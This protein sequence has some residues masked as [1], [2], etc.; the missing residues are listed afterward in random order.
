MKTIKQKIAE[1]ISIVGRG[2]VAY[3]EQN[4]DEEGLTDVI[5]VDVNSIPELVKE[6]LKLV[7]KKLKQ[8]GI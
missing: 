3:I 4:A 6:L 7:P 5:Q 2:D 8:N 1:P